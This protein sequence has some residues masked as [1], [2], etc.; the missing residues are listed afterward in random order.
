MLARIIGKRSLGKWG[1]GFKLFLLLTLFLFLYFVFNTFVYLRAYSTQLEANVIHHA[2]QVSDLVKRSTRYSMLKNH[3][4]NLAN[5]IDNIGREEGV[6][7]VWIYNKEGKIEFSSRPGLLYQTLEK[8][9]EQCIF[10]HQGDEAKGTIPVENRYRFLQSENG[11]RVLGLINPIENEKSCSSAE[12]HAHDPDEKLLGLLDIQM[13][14]QTVDA[15]VAE[16]RRN[17]ILFSCLMVLLTAALFWG[18][19]HRFVHR[20]VRKL[21]EGTRQVADMNLDYRIDMDSGDELGVLAGSFNRMTDQ[22]K[23]ANI[24]VQEWSSTLEKKVRQKT[25]ELEQAQSRLILVEKMA[26]LGKLSA[27]VAHEINNPMSGILTYAKLSMRN[28]AKG[29]PEEVKDT[30]ENLGVIRD[31]AKRCGDIVKN[32]LAFSRKS[33]AET[34]RNDLN[35]I[36]RRAVNLVQHSFDVKNASIDAQLSDGP[37]SVTCARDGIQQM[38]VALLI[39][40]LEALPEGAGKVT[41][42]TRLREKERLVRLTISD[43]GTGIAQDVLPHIFEPFFTTKEMEKGTGLGLSVVY[44]IVKRH[45]GEVS[46]D[47]RPGEGATFTVDIPSVF[48]GCEDGETT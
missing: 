34:S 20:P 32:L 25:L 11:Y 2:I 21:L 9:A 13:S 17:I 7:G 44:G 1:L 48:S 36:V 24:E 28:L 43:N 39:N 26:S 42:T 40:A 6:E 27:M 30:L 3:R 16:T 46:V 33:P 41:V 37:L 12:C 47:S 29:G 8:D 10:C 22:I 35:A 23:Q 31:E 18:L 5:M 14:L 45:Q 4:E 19:I 38:L 15:S